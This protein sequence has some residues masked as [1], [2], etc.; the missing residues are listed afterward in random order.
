M[1]NFWDYHG[2]FFILFMFFFPRLTMLFATVIHGSFLF[3]LGWLVVPRLTV[4]ILATTY[5]WQQ[6]TT[7]CVIT[8]IWAFSGEYVE[9]TTPFNEDNK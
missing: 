1:N 8:W 6:N 2:F 5:Y 7:L 9:K 3:W 4:A